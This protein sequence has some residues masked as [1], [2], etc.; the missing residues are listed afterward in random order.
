M[1]I[2]WLLW[3][4]LDILDQEV[5]HLRAWF[6]GHVTFVYILSQLNWMIFVYY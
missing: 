5:K 2:I 6:Y 3:L 4:F 1:D